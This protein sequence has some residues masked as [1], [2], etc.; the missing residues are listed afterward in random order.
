MPRIP[1]LADQVPSQEETEEEK[2]ARLRREQRERAGIPPEP[3]DE[4]RRL[5]M[6]LERTVPAAPEVQEQRRQ[7]GRE[8][9]EARLASRRQQ[10]ES[11]QRAPTALDERRFPDLKPPPPQPER[12]PYEAERIPYPAE[13]EPEEPGLIGRVL[14]HRDRVRQGRFERAHPEVAERQRERA[15]A[16]PTAFEGMAERVEA[17][18]QEDM[19]RIS[20]DV[21]EGRRWM[22]QNTSDEFLA[23]VERTVPTFGPVL[24]SM[25]FL[26]LP[27]TPFE[28][29]ELIREIPERFKSVYGPE[30]VIPTMVRETART[31]YDLFDADIPDWV[32]ESQLPDYLDLTDTQRGMYDY[33]AEHPVK[34]SWFRLME[35]VPLAEGAASLW[36]IA[37]QGMEDPSIL[38]G[39]LEGFQETLEDWHLIQQDIDAAQAAISPRT[40][41]LDISFRS[42]TQWQTPV[43]GMTLPDWAGLMVYMGWSG[44]LNRALPGRLGRSMRG[45]GITYT[46][47]QQA[48]LQLSG[49][50]RRQ[51]ARWQRVGATPAEAESAAAALHAYRQT[52]LAGQPASISPARPTGRGAPR[53]PLVRQP[54]VSQFAPEDFRLMNG[55]LGR[56]NQVGAISFWRDFY[57]QSATLGTAFALEALQEGEGLIGAIEGYM[58]APAIHGAFG[59]ALAPIKGGRRVLFDSA[60][61]LKQT[62]G[63]PAWNAWRRVWQQLPVDTRRQWDRFT[64][65]L[66]RRTYDRYEY[67]AKGNQVYR[68]KGRP[69]YETRTFQDPSTGRRYTVDT[70]FLKGVEPGVDG[71]VNVYS[72]KGRPFEASVSWVRSVEYESIDASTMQPVTKKVNVD[73]WPDAADKARYIEE[74]LHDANLPGVAVFMTEGLWEGFSEPSATLVFPRRLTEVE[75]G[76]LENIFMDRQ[77]LNQNSI[78]YYEADPEGLGGRISVRFHEELDQGAK[79]RINEFLSTTDNFQGGT[80]RGQIYETVVEGIDGLDAARLIDQFENEVLPRL[81]D[82]GGGARVATQRGAAT[83]GGEQAAKAATL[84]EQAVEGNRRLERIQREGLQEVAG[85]YLEGPEEGLRA[86]DRHLERLELPKV[87]EAELRAAADAEFRRQ[88]KTT[89]EAVEEAGGGFDQ[90]TIARFKGEREEG[91]IGDETVEAPQRTRGSKEVEA[92][93]AAWVMPDGKAYGH[94]SALRPEGWSSFADSHMSDAARALGLSGEEAIARGKESVVIEFMERTGAVRVSRGRRK[95]GDS[96]SIDFVKPPTPE[97]EAVLWRSIEDRLANHHVVLNI[98]DAERGAFPLEL[99]ILGEGWRH[100]L[101]QKTFGRAINLLRKDLPDRLAEPSMANYNAAQARMLRDSKQIDQDTYERYTHMIDRGV[102]EENQALPDRGGSLASMPPGAAAAGALSMLVMARQFQ[103]GAFGENDRWWGYTLEAAIAIGGFWGMKRALHSYWKAGGGR[104]G[105]LAAWERMY[106]HNAGLDNRVLFSIGGAAEKLPRLVPEV[107]PKERKRPGKVRTQA[108]VERAMAE[109]RAELLAERGRESLVTEQQRAQYDYFREQFPDTHE[110]LD[111]ARVSEKAGREWYRKSR[112]EIERIFGA[113][114][115][116]FM[117][118]LSSFSP[119]SSVESNF[120]N[121]LKAYE[122]VRG[123]RYNSVAQMRRALWRVSADASWRKNVLRVFDNFPKGDYSLSGNKVNNFLQA[124]MGWKDGVA[125]DMWMYATFG[126]LKLKKTKGGELAWDSR[127]FDEPGYRRAIQDTVTEMATELG[128]SPAEVQAALWTTAKVAWEELG[129]RPTRVGDVADVRASMLSL[130]DLVRDPEAQQALLEGRLIEEAGPGLLKSELRSLSKRSGGILSLYR[131]SGETIFNRPIVDFQRQARAEAGGDLA[132]AL[133]GGQRGVGAW[134]EGRA[135]RIMDTGAVFQKKKKGPAR[136]GTGKLK[137]P[138]RRT[139]TAMSELEW[140]IVTG[141]ITRADGARKIA[142]IQSHGRWDPSRLTFSQRQMMAD[143]GLSER[144]K[145]EEIENLRVRDTED[146]SVNQQ[147]TLWG[148]TGQAAAMSL[149]PWWLA[150]DDDS[151]LPSALG[152][153]AAILGGLMGLRYAGRMARWM[154]RKGSRARDLEALSTRADILSNLGDALGGLELRRTEARKTPKTKGEVAAMA[155]DFKAASEGVRVE[156]ERLLG[157]E[158]NPENRKSFETGLANWIRGDKLSDPQRTQV[159]AMLG[160]LRD[161]GYEHVVQALDRARNDFAE[162]K[163]ESAFWAYHRVVNRGDPNAAGGFLFKDFWRKAYFHIWNNYEPF[164]E[165]VKMVAGERDVSLDLNAELAARLARGVGGLAE[166]FLDDAPRDFNT[167]QPRADVRSLRGVVDMVRAIDPTVGPQEFEAY[168]GSL[169]VKEIFETR[170][171]DVAAAIAKARESESRI[172]GMTYDQALENVQRYGG[173]YAEAH[174]ELMKYMNSVLEYA[175]DGEL[176]SG[177]EFRALTERYPNYVPFFTIPE[178]GQF[179]MGH[180]VRGGMRH[181]FAPIKRWKGPVAEPNMGLMWTNIGVHTN[182]MLEAVARQ[183]VSRSLG[184]LAEMDGGDLWLKRTASTQFRETTLT[185]K[186]LHRQVAERMIEEGIPES[187]FDWAIN[188]PDLLFNIFAPRSRMKPGQENFISVLQP[189]G[190]RKF[191]EVLDPHMIEAL[192]QGSQLSR[193][194]WFQWLKGGAGILRAGATSLS[195]AFVVRNPVRDNIQAFVVSEYGFKPGVD[196]ARGL[197]HLWGKDEMYWDWKASG[198]DRTAVVN[199]DRNHLRSEWLREMERSTGNRPMFEGTTWKSLQLLNPLHMLRLASEFMENA[200]RMGAYSRAVKG[201]PRIEGRGMRPEGLT[202]ERMLLGAEESREVSVD[203]SRHGA[204]T[205]FFRGSVAFWNAQL[206]GYDKTFRAI[207]N[208]PVRSSYRAFMAITVPSL[209][210]FY[211]NKDDPDYYDIPQYYRDLFWLIR[212]GTGEDGKPIWIRIPKPFELGVVYGSIPERIAEWAYKKDPQSLGDTM[213]EMISRMVGDVAGVSPHFLWTEGAEAF[214][215]REGTPGGPG[216]QSGL[217]PTAVKPVL[218]VITDWDFWRQR[219]VEGSKFEHIDSRYSYGDYTAEWAK[220]MS[221]FLGGKLG[222]P[223]EMQH[224]VYGYTAGAGRLAGD[225]LDNTV[226]RGRGE[227]G[228]RPGRGWENW[229]LVRGFV[230]RYP[231][232]GV[233]SVQDVFELVNHSREIRRTHARLLAEE[234]HE[235]AAEYR[236]QNAWGFGS[237]QGGIGTHLERAFEEIIDLNSK[238]KASINR[239]GLSEEEIRGG[240]SP[241]RDP[242]VIQSDQLLMQAIEQARQVVELARRAREDMSGDA[243]RALRDMYPDPPEAPARPRRRIPYQ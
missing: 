177:E 152:A 221:R 135:E 242:R 68:G 49:V 182:A 137:D 198:G 69:G 189:D 237:N 179:F 134:L 81:D 144:L 127:T 239:T 231:S 123:G 54:H 170:G 1:Y 108:E 35:S 50:S 3:T 70:P 61:R 84:V 78:L 32:G 191:Y 176:I 102:V 118:L 27:R 122:V 150:A 224:L 101:N 154:R 103:S 172:H 149:V 147:E 160:S 92:S 106:G 146:A 143:M 46:A 229:P 133:R 60:T 119:R 194:W 185:G 215:A 71:H 156:A 169:H 227:R 117:G 217:I 209:L 77:G 116:M 14:A 26:G 158:L 64:D 203:F 10:I 233:E 199:L 238:A 40:E 210:N 65:R 93:D 142:E 33:L 130:L 7:S 163:K 37:A 225:I 161:G 73:R 226:F 66:H 232:L 86:L 17:G 228:D 196:M 9:Y 236:E 219:R 98:L 187:Y 121:A 18:I 13:A 202:K 195:P 159:E 39:D 62:Y 75:R 141:A 82:Y 31:A 20:Q 114:A 234:Q 128:W 59:A 207:F 208:N 67:D 34:A 201:G 56:G 140:G 230:A 48:A 178:P 89:R 99:G 107:T 216:I 200:T 88:A 5:S 124:L 197:F 96:T 42:F 74:R 45:A 28:F 213:T 55:L 63:E 190:S 218:E 87:E 72:N 57:R 136:P 112:E 19:D 100:N 157:M 76:R 97:M 52:K 132:G 104:A 167:L 241:S 223:T 131:M 171:D 29:E 111:L 47:E 214:K 94:G 109:P 2:R 11:G 6:E 24:R 51:L 22:R 95:G 148:G 184:R 80:W 168:A 139:R 188:D 16:V 126:A 110:L 15:E 220:Q 105:R 8:R 125:V 21:E 115:T 235:D 211:F 43:L 222:S 240:L 129:W 145:P 120:A 85:R 151:P 30:G 25:E 58:T 91:A 153:S 90:E 12:I 173:R 4:M 193:Q 155:R 113:D 204:S 44:R 162:A 174:G 192:G 183:Q 53:P 205:E 206:Q 164:A 38:G 36:N 243:S 165:M 79:Q 212:A 181:I 83:W 41:D 166:A 186:E 180:V 23:D 175:R 138:A